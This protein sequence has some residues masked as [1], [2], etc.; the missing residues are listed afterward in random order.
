FLLGGNEMMHSRGNIELGLFKETVDR[1][2]TD[3]GWSTI[4]YHLALAH[5]LAHAL[6]FNLMNSSVREQV[7]YNKPN[8][9]KP[10]IIDEIFAT[11]IEN[12][13]RAEQNMPQ[14]T[15]YQNENTFKNNPTLFEQ[16]RVLDQNNQP[17]IEAMQHLNKY[18]ESGLWKD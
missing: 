7:W 5:E 9:S 6:S 13:I 11:M 17:T 4:D 10:V 16:S 15:H 3:K 18:K 14:R 2:L 12:M 1:V 8:S